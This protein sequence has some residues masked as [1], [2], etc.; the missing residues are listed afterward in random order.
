MLRVYLARDRRRA[1]TGRNRAGKGGGMDVMTNQNREP[2]LGKKTGK[3]MCF[4]KV[5]DVPTVTG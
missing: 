3:D 1:K 5:V 2:E 4:L